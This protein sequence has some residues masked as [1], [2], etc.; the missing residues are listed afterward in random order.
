M[1]SQSLEC[2]ISATL[3]AFTL[4]TC[5]KEVPGLHV[6]EIYS[7]SLNLYPEDAPQNILMVVCKGKSSLLFK[8]V[9]MLL[10]GQAG[11]SLEL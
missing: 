8:T 10:W 4:P 11:L 6:L 9:S 1:E 7:M 3:E 2:F 5:Q